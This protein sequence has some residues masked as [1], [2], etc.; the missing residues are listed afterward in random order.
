MRDLNDPKD[1]EYSGSRSKYP[2]LLQ[3][4][5][6]FGLGIGGIVVAFDDLNTYKA[7]ENTTLRG[8]LRPMI[9]VNWFE[10]FIYETGGKYAVFGMMLVVGLLF[11]CFG[12]WRLW[13]WLKLRNQS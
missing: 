7:F 11:I 2:P 3:L 12:I 5:G 9:R 13:S 4:L 10:K 6:Y 8:G 1:F